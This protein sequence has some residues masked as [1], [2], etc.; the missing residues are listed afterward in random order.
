MVTKRIRTFVQ[1]SLEVI[2]GFEVLLASSGAEG[3]ETAARE[4]T[5]AIL[6]NVVMPDMEGPEVLKKLRQ[7]ERCVDI[8]VIFLT[9]R[10][11]LAQ[12][13]HLKSLGA[14]EVL[15]KPLHPMEFAENVRRIISR[16]HPFQSDKLTLLDL[17]ECYLRR[18]EGRVQDLRARFG[19]LKER[20]GGAPSSEGLQKT[21]EVLLYLSNAFHSLAG[22]GTTHGFAAIS[23][24]A[25]SAESCIRGHLEMEAELSGEAMAK[26]S[27][28]I[29]ELDRYREIAV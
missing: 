21:K 25:G 9:A 27:A 5:V 3:V 8:P 13:E 29:D 22:S 20:E 6:L 2:A 10:S 24:V 14:L 4:K 7:D 16:C 28:Y 11:R 23:Q 18:L 19:E 1:V 15:A 12:I 26:I 17:E